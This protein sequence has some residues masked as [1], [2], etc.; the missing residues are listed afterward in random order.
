[1]ANEHLQSNV[2][3]VFVS[4]QMY[5]HHALYDVIFKYV[6]TIEASEVGVLSSKLLEYHMGLCF[7]TLYY[8]RNSK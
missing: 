6:G 8:F 3:F 5:I 4:P 1:M 2:F 7:E